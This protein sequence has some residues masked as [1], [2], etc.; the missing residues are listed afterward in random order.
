MID[1]LIQSTHDPDNWLVC[2]DCGKRSPD[3]SH[4]TC[5]YAEEIHNQSIPVTICDDCYRESC[6]DI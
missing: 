2:E 1:K 6:W 5:P 3:V 4:T